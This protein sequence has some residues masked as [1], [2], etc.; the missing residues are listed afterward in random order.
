MHKPTV[1]KMLKILAKSAPHSPQLVRDV[2]LQC[3][4][5]DESLDVDKLLKG[6]GLKV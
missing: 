5:R 6:A 1:I 2:A 4:D 3:K